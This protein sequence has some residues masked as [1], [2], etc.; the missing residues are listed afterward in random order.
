MRRQ[1]EDQ[2]VR[3]EEEERR[4]ELE[5]QRLRQVARAADKNGDEWQNAAR[6]ATAAIARAQAQPVGVAPRVATPPAAC[7]ESPRQSLNASLLRQAK[8]GP[9][10]NPE[11]GYQ[12]Y[13]RVE[14]LM[15]EEIPGVEWCTPPKHQRYAEETNSKCWQFEWFSVDCSTNSRNGNIKRITPGNR[16]RRTTRSWQSSSEPSSTLS[17]SLPCES[18]RVGTDDSAYKTWTQW[19]LLF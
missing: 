3:E 7:V 16:S 5:I 9:P 1:L 4:R 14:D 15:R 2:R 18:V 19:I 12:V 11:C 6:L 17:T 8:L 13:D 10:A